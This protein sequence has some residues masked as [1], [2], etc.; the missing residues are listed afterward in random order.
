MRLAKLVVDSSLI[1]GFGND[2]A[3]AEIIRAAVR[4]SA[5]NEYWWR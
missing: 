2:S 5:V 3:I 4:P 1:P